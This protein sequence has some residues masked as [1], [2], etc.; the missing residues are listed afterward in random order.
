MLVNVHKLAFNQASSLQ[1]ILDTFST[2][3]ILAT[4]AQHRLVILG[5]FYYRSL[6]CYMCVMISNHIQ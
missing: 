6:M 3:Y 4:T 2:T 5:D 1:L